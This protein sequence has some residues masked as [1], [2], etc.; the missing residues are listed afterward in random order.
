MNGVL[1]RLSVFAMLLLVFTGFSSGATASETASEV[2]S[3]TISVPLSSPEEPWPITVY[4]IKEPS[5]QGIGIM[6]ASPVKVDGVSVTER[7]DWVGKYLYVYPTNGGYYRVSNEST[8]IDVEVTLV[9]SG[10]TYTDPATGFSWKASDESWGSLGAV[11]HFIPVPIKSATSHLT[12]TGWDFDVIGTLEA[13]YVLW[14]YNLHSWSATDWVYYNAVIIE[15][16]SEI[17]YCSILT[18]N[19]IS[20]IVYALPDQGRFGF[21]SRV[22]VNDVLLPDEK[23]TW[24]GRDLYTHEALEG[25]TYVVR[26]CG[27]EYSIQVHFLSPNEVFQDENIR[28]ETPNVVYAQAGIVRIDGVMR[29]QS[30]YTVTG[31]GFNL[32]RP[33]PLTTMWWDFDQGM[34]V[35]EESNS[36]GYYNV[37]LVDV[38]E[39]NPFPPT[40]PY[41]LFVPAL[42]KAPEP[43]QCLELVPQ[44][45]FIWRTEEGLAVCSRGTPIVSGYSAVEATNSRYNW[46]FKDMQ[47]G[48]VTVTADGANINVRQELVAYGRTFIGDYM[49][50]TPRSSSIGVVQYPGVNGKYTY[51]IWGFDY[52][53]TPNEWHWPREYWKNSTWSTAPFY[54]EFTVIRITP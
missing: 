12:I 32:V 26:G 21:N 17:D 14:D 41:S 36:W 1:A 3:E 29:D 31:R 27:L 46:V 30:L 48:N 24:E 7:L 33:W 22:W 43:P 44:V 4:G 50:I 35:G 25:Q 54:S 16:H 39:D 6:S 20:P 5:F 45:P 13:E 53:V 9:G 10:Q 18:P 19:P 49:E 23:L 38:P 28:I 37:M 42:Y 11:E 47:K 52:S 34:F 15:E 2:A 51:S 40:G 8:Y